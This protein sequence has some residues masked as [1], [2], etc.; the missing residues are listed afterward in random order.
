MTTVIPGADALRRRK[1]N[2]QA[3]WPRGAAALGRVRPLALARMDAPFTVG[4]DASAAAAGDDFAHTLIAM[5]AE[6]GHLAPA[7]ARLAPHAPGSA[8][9]PGPPALSAPRAIEAAFARALAPS[10]PSAPDGVKGEDESA[11]R[12]RR[13]REWIFSAAASADLIFLL[14]QSAETWRDEVTGEWT[15]APEPGALENSPVRWALHLADADDVREALESACGTIREFRRRRGLAPARFAAGVS[16]VPLAETFSGDDIITADARSKAALICGVRALAGA[17]EDI[18][19][20]PVYETVSRSAPHAVFENDARTVRL[21]VTGLLAR[22]IRAALVKPQGLSAAAGPHAPAPERTEM[23][24]ASARALAGRFYDDAAAEG[25]RRAALENPDDAAAHMR[26][27]GMLMQGGRP[28]DAAEALRDATAAAHT[29]SD[30]ADAQHGLGLAET[31]AGRLAEAE[32]ALRAAADLR[33]VDAAVRLDLG[34]ALL[35]LGRPAEAE[36]ELRRA[37]DLAPE[38]AAAHLEL[39]RLLRARARPGAA[40]TL[41]RAAELAPGEAKTHHEL[42]QALLAQNEHVKAL[43]ALRRAAEIDPTF[44]NG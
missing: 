44:G 26:L 18:A 7:D 25:L 28:R 38:S 31:R 14:P 23:L 1:I 13:L 30:M 12:A 24:A 32:T 40:E 10:A 15:D 20:L 17:H 5:L 6:L 43:H 4:E 8:E 3:A 2:A 16:P 11:V 35:A 29:A 37:C 22:R 27:A 39:G 42:G 36:A 19:Y 34:R 21:D 9:M 41:T 33:P